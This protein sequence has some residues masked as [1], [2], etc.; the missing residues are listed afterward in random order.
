MRGEVLAFEV[1]VGEL[2][3]LE[4]EGHHGIHDSG[5]H[6]DGEMSP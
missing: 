4:V 2:S 1:G 3:G 5:E 6:T